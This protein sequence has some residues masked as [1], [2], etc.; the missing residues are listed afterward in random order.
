M[1]KY[2]KKIDS[3]ELSRG[4][5]LSLLFIPTKVKFSVLLSRLEKAMASHRNLILYFFIGGSAAFIDVTFFFALYSLFGVFSP[6]ATLCS[7]LL[8]TV[9]AFL[10]NAH[11]N[12]KMTDRFWLRFL[13][14][15]TV[16]GV[17]LILSV[18]MLEV[19]N[20]RLGFDGNLIKILSLPM[21]FVIQYLLNKKIT[22]QSFVKA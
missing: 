13:S 9:Y 8:A 20:V 10:L 7:I 2:T 4:S 3:L 11:F 1:K 22:F 15:A 17:G 18:L 12:F 6:L 14:Y 21:V 5:F 19:F 16:S